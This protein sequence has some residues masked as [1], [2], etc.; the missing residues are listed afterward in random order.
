MQMH[1]IKT[2]SW[3]IGQAGASVHGN[4]YGTDMLQQA[5]STGNVMSF[6]KLWARAVVRSPEAEN[7]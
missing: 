3:A 5:A 4:A 1:V 7:A 6:A 2:V